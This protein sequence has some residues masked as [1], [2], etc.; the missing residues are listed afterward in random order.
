MKD[1]FSVVKKMLECI[2]FISKKL[3]K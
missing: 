2:F 1:A 3:I